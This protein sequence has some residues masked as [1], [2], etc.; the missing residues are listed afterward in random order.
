[1]ALARVLRMTLLALVVGVAA[2]ALGARFASRP[3]AAKSVRAALLEPDAIA[4]V[5]ALLPALR[6]LRAADVDVSVAAYAAAYELRGADDASLA[7]LCE[8][9]ASLDPAVALDRVALWPEPLRG[10]IRDA[11]LRAW[12][13]RNA[14]AAHEWAT[15]PGVDPDAIRSV[16]EGW[17]ASGDPE[18]WAFVARMDPGMERESASIAMM[19]WVMAREGLEGLLSRVEE[20]PDDAPR[21]FKLA[22]FRTATGLVAD[23]DPGLALAFVDR[24]D[25][26]AFGR[27][28][29]RRVAVRW[30]K[31]NAPAAMAYLLDRPPGEERTWAIR[32]AYRRWLR[33]DRSVA[34]AW[35]PDDAALDPR[36]EPLVEVYVVALAN[37]DPEHRERSIRRAIEVADAVP[38]ADV[39]RAALIDL[40][41]IWVFHAPDSA[42]SWLAERGLTDSVRAEA[43]RRRRVMRGATAEPEAP[44]RPRGGKT[45]EAGPEVFNTQ[46]QR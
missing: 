13:R 44:T 11:L 4:R 22:A 29:L 26:S 39:R 9:W 34:L 14:M 41:V 27:G 15:S 7:L 37:D 10:D 18:M 38:D 31:R 45:H 8:A 42:R 3:S 12:A 35:M 20:I 6:D 16:L 46:N 23:H 30:V 21:R 1:M 25:E 32:E 40:G 17:A 36:F 2:F 5:D 19:Q 28:L 24:H 33:L 43:T